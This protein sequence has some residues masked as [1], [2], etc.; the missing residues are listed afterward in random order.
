MA[1]LIE[2]GLIAAVM[3]PTATKPAFAYRVVEGAAS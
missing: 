3:T 2:A 1:S